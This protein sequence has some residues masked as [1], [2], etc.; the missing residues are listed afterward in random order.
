L[1]VN[2]T[3]HEAAL[4][5]PTSDEYLD[6]ETGHQELAMRIVLTTPPAERKAWSTVPP[7]GLTYLAAS[8][9]NMPGVELRIVDA[10]SEGLNADEAIERILRLSPD[11]VGV[12]VTSMTIQRGMKLVI[13]VKR[14]SPRILTMGGGYHATAFD[15]LLLREIPELDMVLRGEADRS[16]PELCRRLL[17]D[18]QIAGVPGLSHRVD[19]EVVRGEPQYIQDL[20]SIPMPDRAALDFKGYWQNFAGMLLPELPRLGEIGSSRGC[21][22]LC[23]FCSKLTA[24]SKKYRM[25][26]AE[27]VFREVQELVE[28]GCRTIFF[29][30]ENFSCDVRRIRKICRMVVDHKLS[31]RFIFEGTLH[32]LSQ[33]VLDLMHE[34]GFDACIVGVESGSDA[35]LRRYKKPGNRREIAAGIRRAKKAHIFV[36]GFFMCGAPGETSLDC[37]ATNEFVRRIRPHSCG[38][39]ELLVFPGSALWDELVGPISEIDTIEATSCRNI[40]TI[41]GQTGKEVIDAR[42]RNFNRAFARSWLTWRRIPEVVDLLR[43]NPTVR[44]VVLNLWRQ[45]KARRALLASWIK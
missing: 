8:V 35:Q 28:D 44:F 2:C 30:D 29:T 22:H 36:D 6:T 25:R 12:S 41:A 16:F 4:A 40:H 45:P 20:D 26:S 13:G 3:E 21:P 10:M 14:A 39:A 34:A 43:F 27:N 23:T 15:D 9:K 1:P 38:M 5:V 19:G 18:E 33:S 32:N 24:G 7:F 42:I 17:R 37:E 11:V 31:V